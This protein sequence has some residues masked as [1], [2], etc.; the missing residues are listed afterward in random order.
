MCALPALARDCAIVDH[1]LCTATLSPGEVQRLA[2]ARVL[3]QRPVLAVLDEATSAMSLDMEACVYAALAEAGIS[4]LS[5]GQRPSLRVLHA[6]T[7]LLQGGGG[8]G[9]RLAEQGSLALQ[10]IAER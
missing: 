6:C 2:I 5:F 8:G 10:E 7:V 3:V 9:W 1:P 4:V